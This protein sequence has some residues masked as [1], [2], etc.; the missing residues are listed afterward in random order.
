MASAPSTITI[1]GAAVPV[2]AVPQTPPIDIAA[3]LASAPFA[4]W[5]RDLDAR[6]AL[7]SI[8][9]QSVDFFGPR[10]GFVKFLATGAF[11]GR[12]V[13]G[14]VFAR[15]G[16]VAILPVLHCAGERWV[17]CCRQPRLPVGRHFLEIPAGMMDGK[18][19]FVGVAAKEMAEE[20]G[21]EIREGELVDLTALAFG[22]GQPAGAGGAEAAAA[23]GPA[24]GMYPSVGAC[25]GAL[26]PDAR[27]RLE[28]APW[29][30]TST[31][32]SQSSSA[33]CTGPSASTQRT[34]RRSMGKSRAALR[35]MR[36]SA[37]SSCATTIFGAPAQM[38]KPCR[39]CCCSSAS[40]QRGGCSSKRAAG[41]TVFLDF[42]DL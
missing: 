17:V 19:S 18:G 35:K 27:A 12:A 11:Q 25:D 1:N 22:E 29:L 10:V 7:Q 20:T 34:S 41:A 16:A 26:A 30:I 39:R 21:I 38:Q 31:P 40:L 28:T 32:R 13:P 15:G 42:V 33:S 36:A 3:A 5:L 24:H 8:C 37:S 23:G 9:F 6:F 4:A 14:I 2:S